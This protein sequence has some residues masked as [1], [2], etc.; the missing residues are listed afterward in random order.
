MEVIRIYEVY[1]DIYFIENVSMDAQLLLL[2][3]LLLKEKIIPWRLILASLIGGVGSVLIFLSG[4]HFGVG[5]YL[6]GNFAR[7][8]YF[9]SLYEECM[10]AKSIVS[11]AYYGDYLSAWN[12]VC[13]HKIYG[14]CR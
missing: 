11:K 7:C 5:I 8:I 2:T 14:V 6:C 12:G 4:I 1:I 10:E 13:I 9:V 3:L